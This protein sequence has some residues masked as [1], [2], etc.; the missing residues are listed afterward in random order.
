MRIDCSIHG[1]QS[2]LQI[3]P[4]IKR[5]P[6]RADRDRG[7]VHVVYEYQG[8]PVDSYLLSAEFATA[9]DIPDGVFPLPDDYP[10][11]INEVAIV[12]RKCFE[13]MPGRG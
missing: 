1:C 13:A 3:S 11:W 10:P 7:G 9:H 5:D 4:D 6:R 12:G 2:V 8:M